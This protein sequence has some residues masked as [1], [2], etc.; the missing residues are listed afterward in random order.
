MQPTNDEHAGRTHLTLA[1]DN[2]GW[3]L[4]TSYFTETQ[5]DKSANSVAMHHKNL[6]LWEMTTEAIVLHYT[7]KH[8]VKLSK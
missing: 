8:D 1:C 7:R 6:T 3:K 5:I 2:C 4:D